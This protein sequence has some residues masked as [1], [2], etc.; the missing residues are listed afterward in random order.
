MKKRDLIE[1]AKKMG[2]PILFYE[3]EKTYL[4]PEEIEKAVPYSKYGSFTLTNDYWFK[5]KIK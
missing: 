1:M 4:F 3:N 5:I 2:V